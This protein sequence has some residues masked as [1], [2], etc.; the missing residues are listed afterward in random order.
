MAAGV[1][2][3]L[4]FTPFAGGGVEVWATGVAEAICFLI[5]LL[6]LAKS[7]ILAHGRGTFRLG[8]GELGAMALA[9]A[10]LTLLIGQLLPMPPGLLRLLS[11]HSFE[12]Y[13]KSLPG[14]PDRVV[15]QDAAYVHPPPQNA[16]GMVTVLPT[17]D[18]VRRG[19]AV[20]F[21]PPPTVDA[22]RARGAASPLAS[23]RWRSMS[24][25]PI[26]TRA[27]LLKCAAYAAL[28]FAVIFYRSGAGD[29]RAERALRRLLLLLV[30][31]SAVAVAMAGLSQ[32]AFS[33]APAQHRASGPFVNPD[34]FANYL[35]MVLPLAIAGALFRVPLEPAGEFSGFQLLC[36][37]AALLLTAAIVISL[38]R[39]GWIEIGLGILTF[40]Y[41]MRTRAHHRA[42]DDSPRD[43]HGAARWLLP[44]GIGLLAVAVVS[45]A[46][47]GPAAR[48]RAAGRMAESVAAGVGFWD[49]IDT[50]IDSA[51][52]VRDYPLF[53]SGFDSW[54][55]V[56][57]H[58]QRPPWTMFFNGV[59]QNDYVEVAAE[60]GIVGMVLLGW[61][62]WKIGQYLY[63]GRHF[64]PTRH[65]ALF[66]ALLPAAAI[67]GF[68]ETLDFCMQIPANAVLFV[69]LLALAIRLVRTFGGAPSGPPPGA[70]A[71][72]GVPA[73][74]GIAAITG[75]IGVAYQRETVYPND[76]PYPASTRGNQAVIQSHPASPLPHLWLADRVHDATGAWLIPELKAAI[77]LDPTNPA[78]RD[79]Y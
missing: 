36:A 53:G 64:I 54:A 10:F 47:L 55:T 14:W 15:Y 17:L 77:W 1:G 59:A 22:P 28:F 35:A 71:A 51:A 58:Y 7:F 6:W 70:L 34:H 44:A 45:M 25:A 79:R 48:Q 5:A 65:W 21:T 63:N 26:L 61:L 40:A 20:P 16:A 4:F 19:I 41:G 73:A 12:L 3:L 39:A 29:A 23:P 74:I 33:H 66:A 42:N 68:H 11:P 57:P 43:G 38:S 32:Q 67:M 8:R 37:A 46:L 69:V 60:S 13:Q 30:L 27:G 9:A 2:L 31:A 24:V 50:W 78:G 18:E 52:I 72:V 75:L 56:F 76:V 62:C 49:R